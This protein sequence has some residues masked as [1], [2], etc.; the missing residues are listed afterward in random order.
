VAKDEAGA[1]AQHSSAKVYLELVEN[2][3]PSAKLTGGEPRALTNGQADFVISVDRVGAYKLRAKLE[4]LGT[5]A[6]S[7]E[8]AISAHPPR[9]PA[10]PILINDGAA[11]T[12]SLT[13]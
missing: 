7:S 2:S 11:Y 9:V 3:E 12:R 4:G 1:L 6:E 10:N 8:F 13:R 5:S